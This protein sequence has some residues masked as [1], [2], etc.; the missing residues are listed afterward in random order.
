M[1]IMVQNNVNELFFLTSGSREVIVSRAKY[2]PLKEFGNEISSVFKE[3][4][5]GSGARKGGGTTNRLVYSNPAR[6]RGKKRHLK[7][8]VLSNG[9]LG[10]L[11]VRPR[12]C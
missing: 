5:R 4:S 12:I 11:S 9:S 1:L 6:T 10:Y 7:E 2:K 8:R 3:I